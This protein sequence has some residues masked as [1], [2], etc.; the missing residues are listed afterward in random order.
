MENYKRTGRLSVFLR[1]G[2]SDRGASR[3]SKK[4]E[5]IIDT[6]IGKIYLKAE[7]PHMTAAVEEVDLQCFKH[8][9][10][11]LESI[12]LPS[13]LE[14]ISDTAVSERYW[15]IRYC[16]IPDIGRE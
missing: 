16:P 8:N 11:K 1:K 13:G 6:A 7:S 10:Q 9:I 15:S 5:R 14:S 12:F 3:L 4:V 2:R